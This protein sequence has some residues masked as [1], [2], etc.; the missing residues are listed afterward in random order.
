MAQVYFEDLTDGIPT[1]PA[2]V[3]QVWR[4]DGADGMTEA[5]RFDVATPN[6]LVPS[7]ISLV[8]FGAVHATTDGTW[9]ANTDGT[10]S[11]TPVKWFG[12]PDETVDRTRT[13]MVTGQEAGGGFKTFMVTA[14]F[15]PFYWDGYGD[16]GTVPTADITTTMA[17]LASQSPS[18]GDV[19]VVT[20]SNAALTLPITFSGTLGNEVEIWAQNNKGAQCNQ[21][22]V[23]GSHLKIH[24]LRANGGGDGAFGLLQ[25][26]GS[27][28]EYWHCYFSNPTA[29]SNTSDTDNGQVVRIGTAGGGGGTVFDI[30]FDGC[31][32]H[33]GRK[34][35]GN[36]DYH[37]NVTFAWV[38][39]LTVRNTKVWKLLL[40]RGVTFLD[41][42]NVTYERNWHEEIAGN[43]LRV[44]NANG[45]NIKVN[46][47]RSRDCG[48]TKESNPVY[49]H[50]PHFQFADVGEA[51]SGLTGLEMIGNTMWES[52]PESA[53]KTNV[54][55][56]PSLT[57]AHPGDVGAP[58][59]GTSGTCSDSMSAYNTWGTAGDP[60]KIYY[61]RILNGGPGLQISG[62]TG[63]S[64]TVVN[65]VGI[66]IGDVGGA[67][68]DCDD[69][70]IH[71]CPRAVISVFGGYKMR[72]RRNRGRML[73]D[74]I[75]DPRSTKTP[76][77]PDFFIA[78]RTG[79]F[80]LSMFKGSSAQVQTPDHGECE[81]DENIICCYHEHTA[82]NSYPDVSTNPSRIPNLLQ[83]NPS[84]EQAIQIHVGRPA[85]LTE[86]NTGTI[87]S[88][89]DP[90]SGN[91]AGASAGW[92]TE[93]DQGMDEWL[94]LR[95]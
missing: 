33:D 86:A 77:G 15:D 59:A 36:I 81:W 5:R 88:P 43:A 52:N 40:G 49:Q 17:N 1:G 13:H 76:Q 3:D 75:A 58:Y 11:F 93:I 50:Q 56:K 71:Q 25:T 23:S 20:D 27:N 46:W 4:F 90:D 12:G 21:L 39:G 57:T 8:G 24:G 48:Q 62:T 35:D 87:F 83:P 69:N 14:I 92:T 34:I 45:G 66:T 60:M 68:I 37:G 28:V 19:I 94:Y 6:N 7:T 84:T 2:G 38:N 42:Q 9:R 67:Y 53:D 74:W 72:A 22:T 78:S 29:N 64:E 61:N 47:N 80:S 18:P 91:L 32:M 95:W 10:V 89:T 85:A 65:Q 44:W 30:L 70:I 54:A 55:A 63:I 73:G 41:C 16:Y 31:E 82:Y 26:S 51:Q 79:A